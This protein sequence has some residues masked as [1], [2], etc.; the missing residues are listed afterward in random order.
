MNSDSYYKIEKWAKENGYKVLDRP[1]FHSV[2]IPSWGVLIHTDRNYVD[3]STIIVIH[4]D[5][6]SFYTLRYP[7][8]L[9]SWH[10]YRSRRY[11][12]KEELKEILDEWTKVPVWG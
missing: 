11:S 3:G 1:Y 10:N 9:N 4:D 6:V 5:V 8:Y 7:S 2:G 12:S